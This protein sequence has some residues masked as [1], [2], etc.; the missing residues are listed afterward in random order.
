MTGLPEPSGETFHAPAGSELIGGP[1]GVGFP[2]MLSRTSFVREVRE[3]LT[4]QRLA[5]DCH[6]PFLTSPRP[7]R[8]G[9]PR[10]TRAARPELEAYYA[11]P[12]NR[13]AG[14]GGRMVERL[15]GAAAAQAT[16][17][18]GGSGKLRRESLRP[19]RLRA[20]VLRQPL[21]PLG[22]AVTR[23]GPG[24]GLRVGRG[25]PSPL[26]GGRRGRLAL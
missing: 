12:L 17:G 18:S 10:C 3:R 22:P 7:L 13:H 4:P 23:S 21:L 2:E 15:R 11:D 14:L 24:A 6:K 8:R 1:R 19:L 20:S 26:A 16:R 9:H 25:G 5:G